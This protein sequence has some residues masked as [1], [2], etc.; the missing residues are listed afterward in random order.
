MCGMSEICTGYVCCV[1]KGRDMSSMCHG[2]VAC[3]TGLGCIEQD[4][5]TSKVAR[6]CGTGQGTSGGA[7]KAVRCGLGAGVHHRSRSM[8]RNMLEHVKG[9]HSTSRRDEVHLWWSA[10]VHGAMW[11]MLGIWARQKGGQTCGEAGRISGW[12]L[13]HGGSLRHIIEGLAQELL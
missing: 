1:R 5:D 11:D 10:H 8:H 9:G 2:P 6:A 13:L 12:G 4:Q 7:R 3:L